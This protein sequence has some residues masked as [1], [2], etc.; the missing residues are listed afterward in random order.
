[1]KFWCCSAGPGCWYSSCSS[2]S[3]GAFLHQVS[4]SSICGIQSCLILCNTGSFSS[5]SWQINS[6]FRSSWSKILFL[7]VFN[8]KFQYVD[9]LHQLSCLVIP[10]C[11]YAP[12][13]FS[14]HQGQCLKVAAVLCVDM[15]PLGVAAPLDWGSDYSELEQ[16]GKEPPQFLDLVWQ[17]QGHSLSIIVC[18]KNFLNHL[19]TNSKLSWTFL[20]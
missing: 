2:S 14:H 4:Q 18:I 6:M 5:F 13:F 19:R 12:E 10:R 1:M 16:Q 17:P 7:Q 20:Y 3:C 15:G 8:S 9:L 11:P